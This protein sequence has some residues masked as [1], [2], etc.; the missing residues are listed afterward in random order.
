MMTFNHEMTNNKWMN[1][2]WQGRKKIW[3]KNSAGKQTNKRE[4]S[5]KNFLCL[6]EFKVFFLF[7][8]FPPQ[9]NSRKEKQ[10]EKELTK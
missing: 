1:E 9:P 8:L 7:V 5:Q 6:T 3:K 10:T 4:N 2:W